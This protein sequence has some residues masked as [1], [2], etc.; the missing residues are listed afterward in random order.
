MA[1]RGGSSLLGKSQASRTKLAPEWP[2]REVYSSFSANDARALLIFYPAMIGTSTF[3]S[4][5]RFGTSITRECECKNVSRGN[6]AWISSEI[7][8]RC[9]SWEFK[10]FCRWCERSENANVSESHYDGER[11]LSRAPNPELLSYLLAFLA[12]SQGSGWAARQSGHRN[13][14]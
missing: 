10:R 4:S 6:G 8:S 2:A 3:E 12:R 1:T 11:R 7:C 14:P 5:A 9:T 13:R